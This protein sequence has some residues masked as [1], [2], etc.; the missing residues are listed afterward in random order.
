[1]AMK[2][3]DNTALL[4]KAENAFANKDY[5]NAY[6]YCSELMKGKNRIGCCLYAMCVFS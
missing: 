2:P 5:V 3:A 6:Q 4:E 1:M